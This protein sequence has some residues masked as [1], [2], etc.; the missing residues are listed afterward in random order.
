MIIKSYKVLTKNERVEFFSYL[1]TIKDSKDPAA[2]NMFGDDNHT[3]T[4]LLENSERFSKEGDYQI[5]FNGN[6]IV[7]C[8]GVY[9]SNFSKQVALLGVRLWVD[10]KYRNQSV[11]ASTLLPY[12]KK[13]ALERGCSTLA[14]SFNKYN[15]NL[16]K[17]FQRSRPN[18]KNV[19]KQRTPEMLFYNGVNEVPFSI[20]I[21]N[22]EQW[23]VY[24]SLSEQTFDWEVLKY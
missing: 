2:V 5:V 14:L 9:V 11:T 15:K 16:I 8:G 13:W 18:N 21:Q 10:E 12:Q 19:F 7:C 4:Y 6:E 1:E 17:V 23:V 22:T 20:N 24:E 3:L